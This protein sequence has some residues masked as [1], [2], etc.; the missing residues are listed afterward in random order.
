M[1]MTSTSFHDVTY[2]TNNLWQRLH[3]SY[4]N[5]LSLLSTSCETCGVDKVAME[6][7]FPSLSSIYLS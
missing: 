4:M 2:F 7:A 6:E 3:Y 5:V 1:Q